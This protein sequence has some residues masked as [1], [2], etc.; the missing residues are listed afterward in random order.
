MGF[1]IPIFLPNGFDRILIFKF[2]LSNTFTM[3]KI[4]FPLTKQIKLASPSMEDWFSIVFN[5]RD[6]LRPIKCYSPFI[7]KLRVSLYQ[8]RHVFGRDCPW[9][10]L[11]SLFYFNRVVFYFNFISIDFV[12]LIGL[13]LKLFWK[14][15]LFK[16]TCD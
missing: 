15:N 2:L 8:L 7:F 4:A 3:M 5:L 16:N 1:W 14:W 11:F 13:C 6:S 12:H 10:V 9:I